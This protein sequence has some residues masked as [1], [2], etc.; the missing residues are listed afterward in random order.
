MRFPLRPLASLLL[1]GGLALL[2]CGALAFDSLSFAGPPSRRA[3]PSRRPP[4][5]PSAMLLTARYMIGVNQKVQ[6][7]WKVDSIPLMLRHRLSAVV[8][9]W[10]SPKG[11]L[12]RYKLTQESGN[13]AF[14]RSLRKAIG[15]IKR[16]ASPPPTLHKLL[17]TDG[18]EITFKRRVFRK[19]LLPLRTRVR[20]SVVVPNW[21][22]RVMDRKVRRRPAKRRD[23]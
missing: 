13:K 4:P 17:R 11:K 18:I 8:Q 16:F 2:L 14:D 1:A 10:I 19:K 3:A 6:K 20:S 15:Q 9:L 7:A 21:R 5:P 23:K 22:P 12:L